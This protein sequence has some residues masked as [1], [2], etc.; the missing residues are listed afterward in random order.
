MANPRK[1]PGNGSLTVLMAATT[2]SPAG[3]FALASPLECAKKYWE[4]RVSRKSRSPI[5]IGAKSGRGARNPGTFALG[6]LKRGRALVDVADVGDRSAVE[7]AA[8]TVRVPNP[9]RKARSRPST[10]RAHADLVGPREIRL[11]LI[12][13]TPSLAA[14]RS[15]FD[16]VN[17]TARVVAA[18]PGQLQKFRGAHMHASKKCPVSAATVHQIIWHFASELRPRLLDQARQPGDAINLRG[19]GRQRFHCDRT[20]GGFA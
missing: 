6:N 7:E 9:L 1:G 10:A 15:L 12:N 14:G 3:R 4:K 20:A 5:A 18:I 19:F 16:R 13:S 17:D 8:Q 2:G 11:A